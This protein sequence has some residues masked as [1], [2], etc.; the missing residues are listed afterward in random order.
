MEKNNNHRLLSDWVSVDDEVLMVPFNI[1]YKGLFNFCHVFKGS[2][3]IIIIPTPRLLP[4]AFSCFFEGLHSVRGDKEFL[5][6]SEK[7]H[8]AGK[9]H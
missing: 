6:Y 2:S 9:M 7:M 8:E 3:C 5:K 1:Q 4:V